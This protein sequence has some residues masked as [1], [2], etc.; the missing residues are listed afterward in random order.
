MPSVKGKG[1][2]P[3]ASTTPVN[4]STI[5]RSVRR[6][7]RTIEVTVVAAVV[8]VWIAKIGTNTCCWIDQRIEPR[9]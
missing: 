6:A 5:S 3:S 2:P 7:A 8:S 9:E 1:D 4:L